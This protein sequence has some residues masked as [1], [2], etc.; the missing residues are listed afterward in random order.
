MQQELREFFDEYLANLQTVLA[1]LETKTL[2]KIGELLAAAR[3]EQRTVWVIGNGG[4]ALTAS[5]FVTDLGKGASVGREK[6]FRVI[7]LAE[8]IGIITA[9]GNDI[10]FDDIFVEQL[11]NV[12][13]PNDVLLCY[14]GSGNSENIIRAVDFAQTAGLTTIGITGRSGG[15][16]ADKADIVWQAATDHMGHIEDLHMIVTHLLTYY[17]MK[18]AV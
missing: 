10:D 1:A 2:V 14:S 8:S 5:H 18:P 13:D 11:R 7:G 16:L 6:R 4:S 12:A 15:R 9:M 17:F 3:E